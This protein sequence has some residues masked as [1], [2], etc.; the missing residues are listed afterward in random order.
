[1]RERVGVKGDVKGK[2]RSKRCEE[3]EVESKM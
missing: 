1:M 3:K 2:R